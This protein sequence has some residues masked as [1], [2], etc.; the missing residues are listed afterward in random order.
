M[1]LKLNRGLEGKLKTV[2]APKTLLK[3]R[4]RNNST[5][6]IKKKKALRKKRKSYRM[7]FKKTIDKTIRSVLEKSFRLI[8]ENKN[9]S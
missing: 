2:V 5:T 7:Q 6:D 8:T 4:I 9:S 3:K 1:N